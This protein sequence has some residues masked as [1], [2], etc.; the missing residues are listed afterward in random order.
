MGTYSQQRGC[1]STM[2]NA[3]AFPDSDENLPIENKV[4]QTQWIR[5]QNAVYDDFVKGNQNF[6][7]LAKK[8][9][10]T[11]AK[12]IEMVR[13]VNDYIK[14]SGA[15]KEMAKERLGEMD[16]HYSMLI[17][18]GWNAV[19]DMKNES[20]KA[21][22]IPSALKAIADI[23]AKRQEALTKAGMYDDYEMGDM[24]AESERK[25]EAIKDLLK[26][27]ITKFPATK[28]TILTGLR[29]IQDPNRLPD[30]DSIVGEV[31]DG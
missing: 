10:I 6:T 18:E 23:E 28:T 20:G 30:P 15:F 27:I 25:I 8:H 24:L 3:L 21:D 9:N 4:A 19:E 2:T 1:N 22:K 13:E 29:D 7:A 17:Q 31:K 26:E 11:R 12:A 5:K 16:H 14:Q